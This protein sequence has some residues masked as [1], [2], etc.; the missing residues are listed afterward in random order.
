[1]DPHKILY[2]KGLEGLYI[3]YPAPVDNKNHYFL[4]CFNPGRSTADRAA[5]HIS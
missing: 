3:V 1:M 2:D 4:V 5:T